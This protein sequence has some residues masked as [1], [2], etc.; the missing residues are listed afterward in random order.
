MVYRFRN[1]QVYQTFSQ[2]LFGTGTISIASAGS[3][4]AEIVVSGIRDPGKVKE[5]LDRGRWE[6]KTGE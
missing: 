4:E 2:R 6:Q 5:L 3:G 1:V